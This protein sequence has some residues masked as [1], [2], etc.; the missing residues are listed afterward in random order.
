MFLIQNRPSKTTT[1]IRKRKE[2]CSKG[3]FWIVLG[4]TYYVSHLKNFFF[5]TSM[6]V[7]LKHSMGEEGSKCHKIGPKR[8]YAEVVCLEAG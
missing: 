4:P 6:G 2:I 7:Y 8:I 3:E 1:T 5:K